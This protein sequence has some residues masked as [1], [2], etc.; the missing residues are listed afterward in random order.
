MLYVIVYFTGVLTQSEND[1][2]FVQ[3]KS[4]SKNYDASF[5]PILNDPSH[6]ISDKCM[7][8]VLLG[9]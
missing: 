9:Y 3:F 2:N 4:I 5:E 1:V 7:Y 6:N 8:I